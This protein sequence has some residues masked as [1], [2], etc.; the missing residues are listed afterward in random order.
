M[1]EIERDYPDG[2]PADVMADRRRT[3]VNRYN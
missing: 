3:I 2:R 1:G